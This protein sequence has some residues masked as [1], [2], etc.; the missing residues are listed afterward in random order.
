[1][2]ME[3]PQTLNESLVKY[4]LLNDKEVSLSVSKRS[5]D[6][7]CTCCEPLRRD[8]LLTP[9]YTTSQLCLGLSRWL[10][11]DNGLPQDIHEI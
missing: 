3:A 11:R 2:R 6:L 5:E 4:M 9:I 1:M 7:W 10:K 8:I